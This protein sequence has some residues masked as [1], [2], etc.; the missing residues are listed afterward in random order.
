MECAGAMPNLSGASKSAARD[1]C[2]FSMNI[3]GV[4]FAHYCRSKPMRIFMI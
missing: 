3:I 4:K 1:G 2:T